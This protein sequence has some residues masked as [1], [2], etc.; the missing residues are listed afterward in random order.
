MAPNTIETFLFSRLS[1]TPSCCP[2]HGWKPWVLPRCRHGHHRRHQPVESRDAPLQPLVWCSLLLPWP[3]P[4]YR[5]VKQEDHSSSLRSFQAAC[6]SRAPLGHRALRE[7]DG[8][9]SDDMHAVVVVGFVVCELEA[10]WYQTEKFR[11]ER[12]WCW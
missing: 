8:R 2:S 7:L 11:R 4:P 9:V 10:C 12:V 3:L 1:A 5:H 6:W